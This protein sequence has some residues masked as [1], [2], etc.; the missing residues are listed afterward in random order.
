MESDQNRENR[1]NDINRLVYLQAAYTQQYEILSNEL[2]TYS[3]AQQSLLKNIDM[4]ENYSKIVNSKM[5]VNTGSILFEATAGKFE[6]VLVYVGAGYAVEKTV[7][8]AKEFLKKNEKETAD[9]IER[10]IKERNKIEQTLLEIG[11][12]L[13]ILQGRG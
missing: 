7:D 8:E 1:E 4:L 6:K 2:A 9:T 3:I 5:L 10:L 12:D 13:N 11:Y